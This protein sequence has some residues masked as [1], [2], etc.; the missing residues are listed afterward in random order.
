MVIETG[1]DVTIR[2][3]VRENLKEDLP[4]PLVNQNAQGTA[5][6]IRQ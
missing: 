1:S 6:E 4:R 5:S 2:R 3:S